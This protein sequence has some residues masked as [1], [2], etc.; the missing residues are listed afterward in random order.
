MVLPFNKLQICLIISI[1][2]FFEGISFVQADYSTLR[3]Q[4]RSTNSQDDN[5][6][7][8]A[9]SA[10]ANYQYQYAVLSEG[11]NANEFGHEEERSGHNTRGRYSVL[12][13]D[14][15][16]QVVTYTA[17]EKGYRAE[18]TYEDRGRGGGGGGYSNSKPASSNP[19]PVYAAPPSPS[20]KASGSSADQAGYGLPP[21]PS[22]SGSGDGSS[23]STPTFGQRNSGSFV[24]L[25]RKINGNNHNYNYSF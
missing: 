13:P 9:K 3:R 12:L 2:V 24:K 1:G 4:T 14:G 23:R 16:L 20:P 5:E 6:G 25:R 7:Y 19:S 21:P 8:G 10:I 22:G 11:E 17:D 15:R 18:V